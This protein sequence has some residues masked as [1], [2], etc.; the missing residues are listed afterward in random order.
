VKE[1]K[2]TERPSVT[3][4]GEKKG[5]G[6][7]YALAFGPLSTPKGRGEKEGQGGGRRGMK[8]L[9]SKKRRRGKTQRIL[10][11]VALGDRPDANRAAAAAPENAPPEKERKGK[12]RPGLRLFRNGKLK[13]KERKKRGGKEEGS[14]VEG[15]FFLILLPQASRPK[16]K[17]KRGGEEGE[18]G[19]A[20]FQA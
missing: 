12:R 2:N 4:K 19:G 13:K 20:P 16:K 17:K 8:R 6:G 15:T 10:D 5:G 3:R 11:P 18:E 7:A 14:T 1:K 9:P